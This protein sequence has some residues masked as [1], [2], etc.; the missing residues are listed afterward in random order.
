M[1]LLFAIAIACVLLIPR[2]AAEWKAEYANQPQEVQ[3]WYRNA[4]LTEAA[5]KRIGF[6]KCCAQSEVV[7]TSFK[8]D[9]STGSD[10]WFYLKNGRWEHIP[11]DI[12]H[13][14]ES[15]PGGKATLFVLAHDVLGQSAGTL[16][17]F[18]PPDGGI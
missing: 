2:A 6:A 14:G 17:C 12:V 8:V 16:T 15:A 11:G 3:D 13:W 5:Q 1:R 7:E 10:E 9:R 4:Q 18:W